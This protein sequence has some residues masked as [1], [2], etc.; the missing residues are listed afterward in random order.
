MWKRPPA[1]PHNC[2]TWRAGP[3]RIGLQSRH[4]RPDAS[5][6][7]IHAK[8]VGV[9][10]LLQANDCVRPPDDLR[11]AAH[12]GRAGAPTHWVDNDLLSPSDNR[13]ESSVRLPPL[14]CEGAGYA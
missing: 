7:T 9:S 6:T 10:P 13:Y 12:G 2:E 4:G 5:S 11:L 14:V 1:R 8:Q 3:R